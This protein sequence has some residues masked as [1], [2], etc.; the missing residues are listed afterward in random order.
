MGSKR[1]K[2]DFLGMGSN[3]SYASPDVRR[4]KPDSTALASQYSSNPPYTN[5]NAPKYHSAASHTIA[6]NAGASKDAG[7]SGKRY[8][9]LFGSSF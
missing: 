9:S 7:S 5:N 8:V 3:P 6:N 2:A 1:S 4:S